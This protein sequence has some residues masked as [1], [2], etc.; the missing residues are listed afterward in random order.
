VGGL[1]A[2]SKVNPTADEAG[3]P[4][5]ETL[6]LKLETRFPTYDA[7]GNIGQLVDASGKPVAAYTY[8]PFGNVTEM[9]GAEAAENPWRFC[10]KPVDAGT[11]WLYY[12]YRWY[13]LEMGRWVSR[14]PIE[15]SGGVNLYGFVGNDGVGLVDV[16]G[17]NVGAIAAIASIFLGAANVAAGRQMAGCGDEI[18]FD[19]AKM[20]QCLTCVSK[21]FTVGSVAMGAATVAIITGCVLASQGFA[22]WVCGMTANAAFVIS[23]GWWI[24]DRCE[25]Q[26]KCFSCKEN[27]FA[28]QG[29]CSPIQ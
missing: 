1:L 22:G 4:Q 12:G 16:L 19:G 2:I 24:E 7:N 11:G 18:T 25:A 10:T 13:D 23:L 15:E 28:G 8:D 6:N 5:L 21:W 17:Q 3:G 29:D 26:K 9:A 27:P 20:S 14:D